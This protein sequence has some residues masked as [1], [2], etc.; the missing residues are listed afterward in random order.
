[1]PLTIT[2]SESGIQ[3]S[4][5]GEFTINTVEELMDDLFGLLNL[6]EVNLDLTQLTEFDG[7]ALQL[8]VVLMTEASRK[9]NKLCL[10]PVNDKVEKCMALLG[11][12]KAVPAAAEQHHGP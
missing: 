1:M 6:P 2:S 9:R 3:A 11:F 8:V 7:N 4:I 5:V 12:D 10:A